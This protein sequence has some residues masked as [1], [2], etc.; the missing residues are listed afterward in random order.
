MEMLFLTHRASP[1]P[2]ARAID[3]EQRFYAVVRVQVETSGVAGKD[4][5]VCFKELPS[6]LATF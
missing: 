3:N 4:V 2:T 6:Q 5:C 1:A